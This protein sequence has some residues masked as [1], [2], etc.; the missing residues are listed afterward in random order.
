MQTM[1]RKRK[2]WGS[3][4]SNDRETIWHLPFRS[5]RK[6]AEMSRCNHMLYEDVKAGIMPYRNYN[7]QDETS[8]IQLSLPSK[9]VEEDINLALSRSDSRL[10]NLEEAAASFIREC[11]ST[12]MYQ[13]EATYEIVN[14]T[15]EVEPKIFFSKLENVP[16]KIIKFFGG[17]SFQILPKMEDFGDNLPRFKKITKGKIVVFK[18]PKSYRA[19]YKTWRSQ[20]NTIGKDGVHNLYSKALNEPDYHKKESLKQKINTTDGFKF[21]R[22]AELS[23]TNSIGWDARD[24]PSKYLQEYFSLVR[25]LR[26][27]RFKLKLRNSILDIINN[28][29][30]RLISDPAYT[31]KLEFHGLSTV[32]DIEKAEKDLR[33]GKREFNDIYNS[34]KY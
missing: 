13:G 16:N 21:S 32:E 3:V 25:F 6:E 4:F 33:E 27:E 17:Q 5:G 1:N 26:F 8:L 23:A 10:H 34:F 30:G 18:L 22:L 14:Y 29:L 20:L 31:G 2:A 24:F 9:Q 19:S 7:R 28:N 15:D 11:V 12:I